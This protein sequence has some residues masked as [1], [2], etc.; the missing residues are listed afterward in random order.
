MIDLFGDKI[1]GSAVPSRQLSLFDKTDYRRTERGSLAIIR[2]ENGDVS[3]G[4]LGTRN[5]VTNQRLTFIE[6][7]TGKTHNIPLRCCTMTWNGGLTVLTISDHEMNRN[8]ALWGIFAS[9]RLF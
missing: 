8:T 6:R 5:R 7:E 1:Y 3:Y 4:T 2:R 9:C